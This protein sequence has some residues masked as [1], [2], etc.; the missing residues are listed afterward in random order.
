MSSSL[1][2]ACNAS[3]HSYDTCFNHWFKSYLLLVSPPL[4]SASPKDVAARTK[5]IE[6]KKRQLEKDCG[7]FYS[8]YQGC[9]KKAIDG[10]EGL[11]ELLDSARKEEPLDGWGGIKVITEDDL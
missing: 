3:K 5:A 4:P 10:R 2:E 7:A 6:D 1:S 11:S 8:S 9:L